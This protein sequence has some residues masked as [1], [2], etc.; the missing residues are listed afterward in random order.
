ML[1]GTTV[2]AYSMELNTFLLNRELLARKVKNIKAVL[3]TTA[4]MTSSDGFPLRYLEIGNADVG[5]SYDETDASK[6][7][8]YRTGS[9]ISN[10]TFDEVV[11]KIVNV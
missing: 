11:N 3:Y 9:T 4:A 1:A 7:F 8:L 6:P 2:R 5:Y 10:M